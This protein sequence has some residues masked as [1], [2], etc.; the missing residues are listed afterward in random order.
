MQGLKSGVHNNKKD[1]VSSIK[2]LAGQTALYGLSSIMG[3][4]LNYLLVPLYTRVFSPEAYGVVSEFYAY[5]TFLLVIFT[6]GMETALFHFSRRSEHPDSIYKTILSTITFSSTT[7]AA[8][9][10]LFSK[11]IAAALGYASHPEY[12]S[13][14][15]LILAFDAI[16]SI[17][18]AWLRMEEKAKKFAL[19]KLLNIIFNIG[20]N[21]FFLVFAKGMYEKGT[22][23]G[24][25]L[26]DPAIGVGYVFISNLA[27]SALSLLLF[28][29]SLKRVSFSNDGALIKTMLRYSL[30]LMVA[31]FAGMINETLDRAIYKYLV[32]DKTIALHQLGIYSACYKVAIV[33]TLFIQTFR[34]AAEPFFFSHTKKEK[35]R[36]LNAIVLNYFMAT[37]CF[38]FIVVLLYLN[39]FMYFVGEDFRSGSG[40]VP[41]LLMANLFLGVYIYLSLWYKLSGETHYGAWF[42]IIGAA[43][44]I[45]LLV[46][47]VPVWGYMGA[48]WATLLCYG[49]MMILSFVTGQKHYP[50]PYDIKA[51]LILLTGALAVYFI[52]LKVQHDLSSLSLK[53]SIKIILLFIYASLSW[54]VIRSSNRKISNSEKP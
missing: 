25:L 10:I 37:C 9:L 14:F 28:A 1:R 46:S 17:P 31:G 48:A 21:L 13:W 32:P 33:M 23:M 18:F 27:A 52:N 22:Q 47:M 19:Y 45:A 42:S 39:L 50:I 2:S 24:K 51:L 53:E 36:A 8:L 29:P 11:T 20:L 35:G 3:R 7:I 38:I 15:A 26:Y 12:I 40:V 5:A 30:P 44:T 6:Y 34:Y 16:S 43:I 49:C 41:V 54:K 4:F